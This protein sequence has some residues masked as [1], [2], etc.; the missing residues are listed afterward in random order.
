MP[1]AVVGMLDYLDVQ[2]GQAVLEIGTGTGFTAALLAAMV[3]PTGSVTTVEVDP[4]LAAI[5]QD[6]LASAGCDRVRT[7][8]GDATTDTLSSGPF[9]RIICTAAI[10]LG[11]IPYAWVQQTKPAGL[12]LTPVRADLTS[13]PLVR[14]TVHE[15]GT[16]TGRMVPMGVE[17]MEVRSQRTAQ[18]PDDQFD[19]LDPTADQQTSTIQPWL[20]FTDIVSRWALAVALPS[21]RYDMRAHEYLWLRDPLSGSWASVVPADSGSFLVRQKGIRR[22]WDEAEAAYRWWIGQGKPTGPNW[23]WTIAPQQQTVCLPEETARRVQPG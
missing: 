7:V 15:D 17:F 8:V 14:F 2:A 10:Q 19:W 12:I 1:S 23:E 3:G 5:A 11:R 20:M 6:H 16:A 4:T 22:L 13:G 21:C 18:T 9:D